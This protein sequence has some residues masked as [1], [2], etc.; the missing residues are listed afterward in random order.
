MGAIEDTD[1]N[2]AK[3]W[4]A[5]VVLFSL[6]GLCAL[7]MVVLIALSLLVPPVLEDMVASYTDADPAVLPH[8][9]LTDEEREMVEGRLDA[10]EQALEEGGAVEALVLDERALNGLLSE[11]DGGTQAYLS[12]EDEFLRV[13][14][15]LPLDRDLE[16][17]PWRSSMRGRYINGVAELG[18]R[19]EGDSLW[20]DLVSFEVKGTAVPGWLRRVLQ[21]EI[22]DLEWFESEDARDVVGQLERIGFEAGRLVLYPREAE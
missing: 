8:V 17:G 21:R 12:V 14:L 5:N 18:L 11:D 20:A 7:S 4:L 10:F 22:D 3:R 9:E 13:Q 1:A 15:S 16:L 2:S 6:F 19:I